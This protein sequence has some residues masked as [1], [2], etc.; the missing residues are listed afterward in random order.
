M[1]SLVRRCLNPQMEF[2]GAEPMDTESWL[3]DLS[4]CVFWHPQGILEPVHCGYWGNVCIHIDFCKDIQEIIE[5]APL[6]RENGN[7]GW[8]LVLRFIAFCFYSLNVIVYMLLL[9]YFF[10]NYAQFKCSNLRFLAFNKFSF[11]DLEKW[12]NGEYRE[13]SLYTDSGTETLEGTDWW[14]DVS[15]YIK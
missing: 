5:V 2:A 13:P 4:I 10:F 8:E 15:L 7:L 11:H 3:K 6:S 14:K 12:W 9:N 1:P